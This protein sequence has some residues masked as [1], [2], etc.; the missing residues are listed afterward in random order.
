[1]TEISRVALFGKLNKLAYQS[2]ES[3][4]VFCKMRGNPYV[5]LAH[6]LHQILQGQD[7]DLHRLIGGFDLDPGRVA[8][9]LVRALDALPRGATAVSDLSP[10]LEKTVERAWVYASLLFNATQVRS[11]HLVLGIVKTPR[12]RNVLQSGFWNPPHPA[13]GR[14]RLVNQTLECQGPQY[15]VTADPGVAGD[16]PRMPASLLD[17]Q[18]KVQPHAHLVRG[19]GHNERVN[20]AQ[21]FAHQARHLLSWV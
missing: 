9:D 21:A 3:A 2:I 1:M 13:F 15:L 8:A 7:S 10:H 14:F 17:D 12:L 5:E 18:G 19:D 16:L 6:W 4:T 20:L 11:G